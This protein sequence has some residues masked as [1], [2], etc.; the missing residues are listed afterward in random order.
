[1]KGLGDDM[2]FEEKVYESEFDFGS[3]KRIILMESPETQLVD[4]IYDT[5]NK[6]NETFEKDENAK[7]YL[8]HKIEEYGIEYLEKNE[9]VFTKKDIYN[10]IHKPDSERIQ[11]I[12]LKLG[13]TK[14]AEDDE[15][16][17]I[18]YLKLEYFIF[19]LRYY[20][21]PN[22]KFYDLYKEELK[23]IENIHFGTGENAKYGQ[24]ILEN[25][26][27]EIVCSFISEFD[28]EIE[29][30]DDWTFFYSWT[31]S[32]M[33]EIYVLFT[34]LLEE[35]DYWDNLL[36]AIEDNLDEQN[37][38]YFKEKLEDDEFDYDSILEVIEKYLE[39][40]ILDIKNKITVKKDYYTK[41]PI[42]DLVDYII[43]FDISALVQ[44]VQKYFERYYEIR[45]CR[46]R[47]NVPEAFKEQRVY[48]DELYS[49][50][51]SDVF[52]QWIDKSNKAIA[53]KENMVLNSNILNIID[54]IWETAEMIAEGGAE[55]YNLSIFFKDENNQRY[56]TAD[57]LAS[58]IWTLMN[59]DDSDIY[60]AKNVNIKDRKNSLS[61]SKRKI[62]NEIRAYARSDQQLWHGNKHIPLLLFA[63]I[64]MT[65]SMDSIEEQ[66]DREVCAFIIKL[67]CKLPVVIWSNLDDVSVVQR[68]LYLDR[69]YKTLKEDI[70]N[71]P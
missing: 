50:I 41:N 12:L 2:I 9:K 66:E 7:I 27:D 47:P 43:N 63:I 57:M 31:F 6:I 44:D 22:E 29:Q 42:Y 25:L 32:R 5:I 48:F 36:N 56:I 26:G 37:A 68:F 4:A 16:N 59:L 10:H 34:K 21:F 35:E 24:F 23:S 67:Y 65:A 38:A 46:V 20:I 15:I 70:E 14:P 53:T 40:K 18:L 55:E 17:Y 69:L 11:G 49:F 62:K 71:T 8:A 13:V 19:F 52:L 1:M 64:I 61:Y 39:I 3:D 51:V 54:S 58:L 28:N 60:Y 45:T 33:L 30:T